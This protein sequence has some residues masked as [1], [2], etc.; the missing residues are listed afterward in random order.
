M[1]VKI[2]S[3]S[4][5]DLSPELLEQYGIDLL[6]LTVSLGDRTGKDGIDI[7]PVDIYTYVDTFCTLP[8]TSSINVSEHTAFFSQFISQGYRVVHFCLG[9]GFSSTYQNACLAAEECGNVYVVDSR[10]LSTGQGLLVLKGAEMAQSGHSAKMIHAACSEAVPRVESS[11]VIDSLDYLYKGGRCS[12]LA[13]FGA[14]ILKF[15]PCIEVREGVM[16]PARKYRGQIERVTLQYVED[17]LCNRTDIDTHRIFVTHTRCSDKL[18]DR[19]VERVWELLPDAEEVLVTTAGATIT[20]HCGP[21]ALGV[22]F[23]RKS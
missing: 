18:V 22:L 7:H 20:T 14:N 13:A 19:V 12:A 11:F 5:C 1:Q 8:K 16:L 3:D 17:R 6:P 4:T 23:F 9:S 21:N 10:N 15:K 2:T